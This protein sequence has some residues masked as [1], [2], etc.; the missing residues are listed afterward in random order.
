MANVK[1]KAER[2]FRLVSAPAQ[3]PVD[4]NKLKVGKNYL[5]GDL[6]AIVKDFNE[7][8]RRY[9]KVYDRDFVEDAIQKHDIKKLRLISDHF[10]QTSGIYSRLCR[11]MSFLYKYDWFVT[12]HKY[13]D[14][15][16]PAKVLEG[17]TKSVVFLENCKLKKLFG[18][19]ALEVIKN[20][21][22]YG[23]IVQT[24][25]SATI[26]KLP[27]NYCRSRFKVNGQYAV[28]FNIR[29][30]DDYFENNQYRLDVLKSFP[31]EFQKAYLLYKQGKLP[32]LY[33]GDTL[34]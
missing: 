11:Y 19:I 26:Q 20:G 29:F 28:E 12:P 22:Y 30:F 1:D 8:Q 18:E 14:K 15:I 2:D 23:Y 27:A 3:K 16:S 7:R 5:N 24:K 4:F 13:D 34:G 9:L 17:W 25:T 21:C 32:R 6:T 10:Y 33:T 31:K